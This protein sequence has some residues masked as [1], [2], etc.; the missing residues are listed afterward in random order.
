[1]DD[2]LKCCLLARDDITRP[3]TCDPNKYQ[4]S[5]VCDNSINTY[6]LTNYS[7]PECSCIRAINEGWKAPHCFHAQCATKGY[8]PSSLRQQ[9]C[10]QLDCANNEKLL[11]YDEQQNTPAVIALC[12]SRETQPPPEIAAAFDNLMEINDMRVPITPLA[13]NST[14][15]S[16]DCQSKIVTGLSGTDN[17]LT[18]WYDDL[19]CKEPPYRVIIPE[20]LT[21]MFN[22]DIWL[23]LI[24]LLITTVIILAI[25]TVIRIKKNNQKIEN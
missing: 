9:I 17:V 20:R 3:I 5:E 16:G 8:K 12:Y 24:I 11:T 10:S 2:D 18:N 25:L 21:M 4:G 22:S 23:F 15:F 14:S 19:H 1:M 7:A 6:C 13:G